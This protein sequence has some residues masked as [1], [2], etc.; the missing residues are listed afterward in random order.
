VSFAHILYEKRD[1]VAY[2]TINRPRVMN[3]LH[4]EANLEM[5]AAFD[6]FAKDEACWVAVLTGAGE[7]AFSAGNDLKATAAEASNDDRVTEPRP[8]FGGITRQFD[9]DKPII[10]AVN[11]VAAGG[12]FEMALA[13]DIVVAADTARFGLTEPRVGLI[14]GAGG[15][16]RLVRQTGLKNAMGL[17]LTGHLID[18][19]EAYRLGVVNEVVTLDD[20]NTAVQRWIAAILECSPL[21]IRLTK[22]AAQAGLEGM[23]SIDEALE[24]DA[25]RLAAL[26]ASMDFIE[27][28]RAFV[29]KRRPV[30]SGK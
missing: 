19:Q 5:E 21:S 24:R 6:D 2:V 7:R 9:C 8:R 23:P 18:A 26:L 30:W 22:Q 4:R 13:C 15:I 10:A 16:H 29:E 25:P 27:G 1:R 14:A 3:A 11:G 20:L 28:P 17:L 12:G